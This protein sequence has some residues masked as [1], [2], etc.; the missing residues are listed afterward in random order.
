MMTSRSLTAACLGLVLWQSHPARAGDVPRWQVCD[1]AFKSPA[2]HPNPFQVDFSAEVTGPNGIHFSQLG[3]YD[4]EGTW[5]IRLG[6]NTLGR[7]SVR[8]VSNDPQLDGKTVGDITCVEQKN[9][10]VHGGL[11]VDPEHPH[12]F[13]RED[14]TRFFYS[15]FECDWLWA[16]DLATCDPALP[17][18][19][20][21]LDKLAAHEFNVVYMNVYAHR[22]FGQADQLPNYG[23]P[24]KYAWGGSNDNPDHSVLN[25]AF[26]QHYD[27][28]VRA[29]W[30]R[31]IEA[32]IMIKVYNKHVNWPK[33][34]SPDDD[35][36][37]KNVIAR[38]AP[39]SNVH[40]DFSKESDK[41][42]SLEYKLGRMA[43]IR[44]FD[45]YR[46]L[47]TTH[48]D[49]REYPNYL[50]LLDYRTDQTLKNCHAVALRQRARE[51]W[52]VVNAE[53]GYECG[54]GGTN[55]TPHPISQDALTLFRRAGEVYMAGAFGT[56]YYDYTSWNIVRVNDTP[57]GYAYWR[58]LARFFSQTG[59][60]LMDSDDSL[61]DHGYCL[62]NPGREYIVY[63]PDKTEFTLK[64]EA[65]GKPL[66]VNWFN[67]LTGEGVPA[68]DLK[69][70]QVHFSP[71][72]A[73][74]G[75][76]VLLH[77]G[78]APREMPV[79]RSTFDRL[80]P[81]AKAAQ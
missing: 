11:L 33:I 15:G 77:A 28:V 74:A 24:P 54:A 37:F 69:N 43:L 9:R 63:Q 71:P 73:W 29:L 7:W 22:G 57:P 16:V 39:F 72:A 10:R 35:R 53:Y 41:E 14:G 65:V 60:W 13:I 58:N 19:S 18:T 36:Y 3:F 44:R 25:L 61:V 80:L 49:Q 34:G 30:E 64:V 70:G 46:R 55:D 32:H 52:P 4:G 40:F 38:Y 79:V 81:R 66:A 1:L 21:L 68:G 67:P 78:Q 47:L 56:Y 48:T 6:P 26:W 62:A 45:P 51:P 23:P 42:K 8:T 27:R 5:K 12:S 76:P 75:G 31:G 17:Q 59:Y 50:G 2:S 20:I